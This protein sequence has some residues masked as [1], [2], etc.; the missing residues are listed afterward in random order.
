MQV[1]EFREFKRRIEYVDGIAGDKSIVLRDIQLCKSL[2]EFMDARAQLWGMEPQSADKKKAEEKV[3]N[4]SK[5]EFAL[6]ILS[7]C[8]RRTIRRR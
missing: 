2:V 1:F 6:I 3:S 5:N 4:C 8:R 7:G